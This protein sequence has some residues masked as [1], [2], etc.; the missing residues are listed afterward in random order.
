[1][2]TTHHR[3]HRSCGI[4]ALALAVLLV[5]CVETLPKTA[6]SRVKD[7]AY[8]PG[9]T[10]PPAVDRIIRWHMAEDKL[11]ADLRKISYARGGGV[12]SKTRLV[13]LRY[14][15]LEGSIEENLKG[16]MESLSVSIPAGS[17]S[18]KD[19]AAL[20]EM[21]NEIALYI[22]NR[23]LTS[24]LVITGA[25]DLVSML[26]KQ[27]RASAPGIVCETTSYSTS[28]V[29]EVSIVTTEHSYKTW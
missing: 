25:R 11:E 15:T 9:W 22:V 14:K 5:G 21:V 20:A 16:S 4:T 29:L 19:E 26:D 3:S 1:M 10:K 8:I 17:L 12:S 24:K 7:A 13:T 23:P 6:A 27:A 2:D 18:A 28:S